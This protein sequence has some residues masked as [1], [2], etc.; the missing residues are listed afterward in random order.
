MVDLQRELAAVL[1][2]HA[3]LRDQSRVVDE[4]VELR[5]RLGELAHLGERG[6]V[7][8]VHARGAD[9]LRRRLG[10]RAVAAVD[11]DLHAAAA[12][13][14]GDAAPETVGR[15]GDEDGGHLSSVDQPS[16]ICVPRAS[17]LTIRS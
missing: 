17:L 15:A 6:Q 3:V 7:G 1:G 16:R 9:L 11:V 12:E 5:Q 10:A 4:D 8:E 2:D 13:L 14:G